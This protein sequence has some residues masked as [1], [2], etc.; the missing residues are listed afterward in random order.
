MLQLQNSCHSFL[1]NDR[2]KSQIEVIRIQ[3][4][5]KRIVQSIDD[6]LDELKRL[7]NQDITIEQ[8]CEEFLKL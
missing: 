4:Q 8:V 6:A 2:T 1:R 7:V 5:A 3:W